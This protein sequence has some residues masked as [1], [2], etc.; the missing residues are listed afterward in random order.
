[1]ISAP[2]LK[3]SGS[4]LIHSPAIERGASPRSVAVESLSKLGLSSS[5]FY[6]MTNR[7]SRADG[8]VYSTE[9]GRMC[10]AC[11]K[12]AAQCVCRQNKPQNPG[13]GAVRVGRET[14]GRKGKG[15]SV[16]T[17]L[18]MNA[19]AL[20]ALCTQ[21]KKRCGSGGTVREG[22]IEIQGDHRDTL[23]AELAKQ[24]IVAKRSGG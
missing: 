19:G 15:V 24:G 13:T 7:S 2:E 12:P 21:L 4:T 6:I 5:A 16:I 8:I 10:P 18:A 14:K 3:S 22:V 11:G 17:G 9:H 1:M 20:E 23:I